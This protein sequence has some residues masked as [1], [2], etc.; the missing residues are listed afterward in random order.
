MSVC[1]YCRELT[2]ISFYGCGGIGSSDDY[3]FLSDLARLP[4]LV[5][6]NLVG[7]YACYWGVFGLLCQLSDETNVR[8]TEEELEVVL[9]ETIFGP[10]DEEDDRTLATPSFVKLS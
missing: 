4:S 8:R 6:S 7:T 2:S 10:L 9:D 5:Y 3:H 1:C